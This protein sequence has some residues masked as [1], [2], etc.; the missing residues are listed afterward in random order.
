M[1]YSGMYDEVSL[2][3][4]RIEILPLKCRV[5]ESVNLETVVGYP[6]SAAS[7]RLGIVSQCMLVTRDGAFSGVN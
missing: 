1:K 2:P 4:V 5:V 7:C 6:L 3:A